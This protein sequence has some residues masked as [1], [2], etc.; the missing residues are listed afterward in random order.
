MTLKSLFSS[1][2]TIFFILNKVYYT[3]VFL[4]IDISYLFITKQI[5]DWDTIL[6]YFGYFLG[7]NTL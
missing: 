1:N 6:T 7:Q 3:L 2:V 4:L 5:S